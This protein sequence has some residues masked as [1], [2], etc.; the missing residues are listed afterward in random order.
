VDDRFEDAAPEYGALV[1]D[2]IAFSG[3]EHAYFVRRKAEAL[4][5]IARRHLGAPESLRV[6]D[7]GC[8]VGEMEANLAVPFGTIVGAEPSAE[9]AFAA[10]GQTDLHP[11]NCDGRS[12]PLADNSMDLTFTVNVL[13]H[14][15][16]PHRDAMIEEMVRI[17]RPGGLVV[18][19]EHN[20]LNPLT[21][22]SVARC[23]FDEG[24]ELLWARE[25]RRRFRRAGLTEAERRYVLFT[26]FDVS[27]QHRVENYLGRLPLGAQHYLAGRVGSSEV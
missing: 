11:V 26:P 5:S 12:L 23:E 7:I 17:T 27:W 15:D 4:T 10:N 14:V 6:A 18:A 20:P 8:G 21:R 16:P 2:S 1:Q 13:H 9:S 25:L 24:V 22:M 3:Q 19:F